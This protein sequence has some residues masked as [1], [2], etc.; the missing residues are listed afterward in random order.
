MGWFSLKLWEVIFAGF[1]FVR[2]LKTSKKCEHNKTGPNSNSIKT[3]NNCLVVLHCS[4]NF[5][6]YKK[7]F[8]LYKS[9]L[10]LDFQ[11]S[12]KKKKK[13]KRKKERKKSGFL[14]N[15]HV[16]NIYSFLIFIIVMFAS[17]QIQY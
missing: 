8:S 12:K 14:P 17:K 4:P 5:E 16:L 2:Y 10:H 7:K 3:E 13:K 9:I 15:F 6:N 11:S 1:I